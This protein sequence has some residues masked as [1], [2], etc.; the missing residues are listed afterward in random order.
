M[1]A[2]DQVSRAALRVAAAAAAAWWLLL[3]GLLVVTGIGLLF[4]AF[5]HTP[6]IEAVAWLWGIE[7][8]TVALIWIVFLAGLK[9]S[10]TLWAGAC[11][12]LSLYARGLRRAA[13]MAGPEA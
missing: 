8:E 3:I 9:F 1:S 4:L 5:V 10:L 12:F 13:A 11:V 2:S 7:P 6:L